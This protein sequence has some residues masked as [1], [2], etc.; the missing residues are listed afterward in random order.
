VV[1]AAVVGSMVVAVA[2]FVGVVAAA[3]G[4][5]AV[6]ALVAAVFAVAVSAADSGVDLEEAMDTGT[7]GLGTALDSVSAWGIG[8]DTVIHIIM[9]IRVTTVTVIPLTII[10]THIPLTIQVQQ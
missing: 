8:E 2:D 5:V 4:F 1:V 6:A 3:V 7:A 9:G 10:P